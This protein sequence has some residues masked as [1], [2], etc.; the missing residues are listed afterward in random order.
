MLLK[1]QDSYFWDWLL[2]TLSKTVIGLQQEVNFLSTIKLDNLMNCQA[3]IDQANVRQFSDSHQVDFK[4][5]LVSICKTVFRQF[6]GWPPAVVR[7]SSGGRQA[8]VS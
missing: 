4:Q 2:D 5:S 7:Q 8:V 6:A 1:I 3:V